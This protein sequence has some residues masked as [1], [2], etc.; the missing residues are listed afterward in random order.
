MHGCQNISF[1]AI[2]LLN[3]EILYKSYSR[4]IVP[5]QCYA[6][7]KLKL[8]VF[9][10]KILT[11][12]G[13]LSKT[14]DCW[15]RLF[16]YLTMMCYDMLKVE[17][18]D[19]GTDYCPCYLAEA[20][21]CIMCSLLQGK[22]FCDCH[23]SGVCIYQEYLW[24]GSKAKSRRK[25]ISSKIMEKKYK[26]KDL[27]ILTLRVPHEM[28]RNLQEPGSYVF[29]RGY[30]DN[31]SFDTPTAV[32][33]ADEIEGIIVVAINI[34]GPKT[35]LLEKCSDE[36]YLKGPYWN[37]L[38]GQKYIKGTYNSNCLVVLGGVS[39]ASGALVINRLIK[40]KNDVTVFINNSDVIFI[41]EYVNKE[42]KFFEEDI[43]S[44]KG[45]KFLKELVSDKNIRCIYSGGSNEQHM[46]ILNLINMYNPEAYLAV[47]NNNKLCCGEGVCGSCEIDI[48]G[49]KARA[50]KI[51]F[52]V[53][54]VMK[55]T[56]G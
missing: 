2:D 16:A 56:Y 9:F 50:C 14:E 53:R 30:S 49:Q 29:L 42:V 12:L 37:S 20:G 32:I 51:Q 46:N 40:N 52:D 45:Q 5:V 22:H 31:P 6:H 7:R 24:S 54:K 1:L 3:F 34:K 38:F 27:F 17:C 41:K 15:G 23:W 36:L 13:I 4:S 47:S 43:L 35:K 33:Y 25:T 18:V 39:Q 48:N 10:P 21:E 8:S 55:D 19:M 44:E 26:K 11:L 28:A